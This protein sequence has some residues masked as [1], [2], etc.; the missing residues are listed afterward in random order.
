MNDKTVIY[1]C[2]TL[3]YTRRGLCLLFFWLLW[4][5]FCLVLLE[6]LRP[7]IMPLI[8]RAHNASNFTIGLLCGTVPSLLN[9]M[10]DPVI[11]TAS[12][13]TRTRW[14]RRMPYLLCGVPFVSLFLILIGYA[15]VIGT[16]LTKFTAG[17]RDNL[18]IMVVGLL[19]IFVTGF[20]FFDLFAGCV[21][22]Y[23]FSDVVPKEWIGRFNGFFRIASSC[24]GLA[25]NLVVMPY[26]KTHMALIC[27][28]VAL[29]YFFGFGGM[30]LQVREGEYEDIP[31]GKYSG[32]WQNVKEYA[33]ECFS[34]PYWMIM[35][36][37]LGLNYAS[38]VCRSLFNLLYATESLHLTTAQYG[39]LMAVGSL[40]II[41]L[42]IPVGFLIDRF[43]PLRV[44][45]AG[46][47]LVIAVNLL[48]FFFCKGYLSFAITTGLLTTVY[49]LQNCSGLP[50]VIRLFPEA[51]FGQFSSANAMVKAIMLIVANAVGGY[52]ID[53]FGYQYIFVW[54]FF[55]TIFCAAAMQYVYCHWKKRGGDK[56]YKAP[57]VQEKIVQRG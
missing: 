46:A 8:L 36:T 2:G 26:V 56:D 3:S 37:G 39:Q 20:C 45:L 28:I 54:D 29:I 24:A 15:D 41:S 22:Y 43:H 50:L 19:C 49:V 17:G 7:I 23:L 16:W 9:F 44:Y 18:E 33:R 57:T 31:Q 55:F 4:G 34:M 52:F 35:F 40:I 53:C 14:G 12:D 51:Q 27:V 11:S 47:Y 38:A 30:C 5:D 32:I 6:N 13:R 10:V 1:R 48:A 25:L 42:A 21:Y